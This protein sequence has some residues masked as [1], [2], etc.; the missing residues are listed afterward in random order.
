MKHTLIIICFLFWK[1]TTFGQTKSDCFEIKY[2]DFFD[3]EDLAT[4]K[5]PASELDQLLKT[6]FTKNEKE[7]IDSS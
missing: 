5:W 3:I 4:V 2:L 7:K 6:D 1:I